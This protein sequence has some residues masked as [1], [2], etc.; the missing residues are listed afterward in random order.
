[1]NANVKW[2]STML[3]L[4]FVTGTAWAAVP[5][6]GHVVGID[7]RV[8][9]QNEQGKIRELELK[10]AI[11]LNDVIRTGPNA[12]LQ[13]M[14]NDNTLFAQG[15]NSEMKIDEY[16]YSPENAKENSF[17]A[18]LFK[19]IFRV[20]TGTITDLNPSRF[21]VKT[22]RAKIGIRGCE[23]GFHMRPDRDE[24]FVVRI[25]A[26]KRITV[27]PVSGTRTGG[28]WFRRDAGLELT[29]PGVVTVRDQG[30]MQRRGLR[31]DD[32]R[33]INAATTPQQPVPSAPDTEGDIPPDDMAGYHDPQRDVRRDTDA[34]EVEEVAPEQPR[35]VNPEFELG[36][37][38]IQESE[39]FAFNP[40]SR[41]ETPRPGGNG[42]DGPAPQPDP[43]PR[44]QPEPGPQPQ[45]PEPTKGSWTYHGYA[46]AM[47]RPAE[48]ENANTP[49]LDPPHIYENKDPQ[50]VTV[51]FNRDTG[52][53][54][55]R[56][57][58]EEVATGNEYDLGEPDR[59]GNVQ[60]DNFV[61]EYDS[62]GNDL[63]LVNREGGE[64][65]TWGEWNGEQEVDTTTRNAGRDEI[66]GDYVSGKILSAT[67]VD[68]MASLSST[69]TLTGQGRT[70]AVF[71][72][73]YNS[74]VASMQGR[75][76]MVVTL[77][78]GRQEW[79]G[80]YDAAGG[81]YALSV[82]VPEG[83]PIVNGRLQGRPSQYSLEHNG[84]VL[85]NGS[86]VIEGGMDG[87]LVGS[88]QNGRPRVT[89]AIGKGNFKHQD[90]SRVDL[91]YGTDLN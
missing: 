67:E 22:G 80:R 41:P 81:G 3:I 36:D 19:G 23:L 89:G 69:R 58:L 76:D 14:F 48:A 10:S 39:Q 26:G 51:H 30:R 27:N 56:I 31:P 65:W 70:T 33:I 7:G 43:G 21:R 5:V 62:E 78:G 45:P 25:P 44:P 20:I 49:V 87:N 13:I 68:A 60:G 88:V 12:R 42:Q 24:V 1:M 52:K 9:A 32:I 38:T 63:T 90:Y 6:V 74:P 84:T 83:T 50:Q 61:A 54:D 46:I 64:D 35:P 85:Y 34:G 82:V 16:V 11:F 66:S 72:D 29:A 47:T 2:I 28:G 91:L 59:T 53:S 77:G 18:E 4:V 40:V 73:M 17:G 37:N 15:E 79:G 71:S 86:Q 57:Q 75:A 8:T 55:I